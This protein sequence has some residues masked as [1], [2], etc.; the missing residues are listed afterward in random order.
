MLC[1]LSMYGL[2]GVGVGGVV[3]GL[4]VGLGGEMIF[5]R[6]FSMRWFWKWW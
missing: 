4:V 2:I 6:K 5:L 1:N 3:M